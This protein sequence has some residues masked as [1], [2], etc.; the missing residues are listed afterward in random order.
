MHLESQNARTQTVPGDAH[1]TSDSYY[2]IGRLIQS[3][4]M[5]AC[6]FFSDP[7]PTITLEGTIQ[8]QKKFVRATELSIQ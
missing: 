5:L 1:G 2:E 3:H 6:I 8:F 7:F 4:N